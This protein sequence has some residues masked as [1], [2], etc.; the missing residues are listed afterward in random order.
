MTEWS[1][2]FLQYREKAKVELSGPDVILL[3]DTIRPYFLDNDP[4]TSSSVLHFELKTFKARVNETWEK[5]QREL[6]MGLELAEE[7]AESN[8]SGIDQLQGSAKDV[9]LWLAEVS[10]VSNIDD[11]TGELEFSVE[12]VNPELA[13]PDRQVCEPNSE[14]DHSEDKTSAAF[15]DSEVTVDRL[16]HSSVLTP[17]QLSSVLDFRQFVEGF[18]HRHLSAHLNALRMQSGVCTIFHVQSAYIFF[19]TTVGM[20]LM[21]SFPQPKLLKMYDDGMKQSFGAVTCLD[22]VIDTRGDGFLVA[23]HKSGQVCL[24]SIGDRKLMSSFRAHVSSVSSVF[25]LSGKGIISTDISGSIFFSTFR[26]G[27]FSTTVQSDVV[28]EEKN[29]C[30]LQ[31]VSSYVAAADCKVCAV[32]REK[33]LI[34]CTLEPRLWFNS[35]PVRF[36]ESENVSTDLKASL[37]ALRDGDPPLLSVFCSVRGELIVYQLVIE[38]TLKPTQQNAALAPRFSV[39]AVEVTRHQIELSSINVS[40]MFWVSQSL[41]VMYG[42]DSAF[43]VDPFTGDQSCIIH[44][45]PEKSLQFAFSLP[46]F[47]FLLLDLSEIQEYRIRLWNEHLEEL[48]SREEWLRALQLSEN[49][50]LGNIP[51]AVGLPRNVELKRSQCGPVFAQLLQAIA[52]KCFLAF[53]SVKDA[54]LILE[55]CFLFASRTRFSNLLFKDLYGYLYEQQVASPDFADFERV[56]FQLT[57]SFRGSFQEQEVMYPDFCI[58][59]FLDVCEKD[60]GSEDFLEAVLH[61]SST[62]DIVS[63][64]S[65]AFSRYMWKFFYAC[66]RMVGLHPVEGLD[67]VL[68]FVHPF[69]FGAATVSL[70]T[71]RFEELT[72]A[73]YEYVDIAVKDPSTVGFRMDFLLKLLLPCSLGLPVR[74]RLLFELHSEKCI[75]LCTFIIFQVSS[76]ISTR[77]L[78]SLASQAKVTPKEHIT[79]IRQSLLDTLLSSAFDF[80]SDPFFASSI[81]SATKNLVPLYML[82]ASVAASNFAKGIHISQDAFHRCIVGVIHSSV[83]SDMEREQIVIRL[84]ESSAEAQVPLDFDKI[85]KLCDLAGMMLATAVIYGITREFSSAIRTFLVLIKQK[86]QGTPDNGVTSNGQDHVTLQLFEFLR[87]AIALYREDTRLRDAFV[88]HLD[89]LFSISSEDTQ[90]LF[91][92]VF[93]NRPDWV[94]E[95]DGVPLLQFQ[96]LSDWVIV[97]EP[98]GV[99]DSNVPF[100]VQLT[101]TFVRLLCEFERDSAYPFLLRHSS[102]RLEICLDSAAKFRVRDAAA[103][104]LEK[105]GDILSAIKELMTGVLELFDVAY[106]AMMEKRA[107]HLDH[108]RVSRFVRQAIDICARSSQT[109]AEGSLQNCWFFLLDHLIHLRRK[110]FGRLDTL[111]ASLDVIDASVMKNT[112]KNEQLKAKALRTKFELEAKLKE[113]PYNDNYRKSMIQ[114]DDMLA[115]L[116]QRETD[117]ALLPI[118]RETAGIQIPF[119]E[120]CLSQ[121]SDCVE[122]LLTSMVHFVPISLVLG[123]V[124]HEHGRDTVRLFRNTLLFMLDQYQFERSITAAVRRMMADDCIFLFDQEVFSG[125]QSYRPDNVQPSSEIV[126][127]RE[128]AASRIRRVLGGRSIPSKH[129]D[130]VRKE[131]NSSLETFGRPSVRKFALG[132]AMVEVDISSIWN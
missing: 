130:G 98:D 70:S 110:F 26:Q 95:L 67:K 72:C 101:E 25:A 127:K 66:H 4:L 5:T 131:K 33:D 59:R 87:H 85:L 1:H 115:K 50:F 64:A 81:S 28:L 21:Y 108:L 65:K 69:L 68:L 120:E 11:K 7:L 82:V 107:L 47:R 58:L 40:R 113:Q 6:R 93:K 75:S 31:A 83:L 44:A 61:V 35:L 105:T 52:N 45:E 88:E 129:P 123:K 22:V 114:V 23:G 48:V 3:E 62:Q 117:S 89:V 125:N 74:L 49:L 119:C 15:N 102:Y 17:A 42:T 53:S 91:N 86:A 36:D 96:Y 30:I 18:N 29:T 12:R 92:E 9:L 32:I 80:S 71:V 37:A 55:R 39:G 13:A 51:L 126:S 54:K 90:N 56:F 79:G 118:D 112:S 84:L 19:G 10:D 63:F 14:E 111:K 106:S 97:N 43:L 20:V 2:V 41:V 78:E 109:S 76:V 77:E 16:W 46:N 34:L 116:S 103:F 27:V 60:E 104:L 132:S 8:L 124:V 73:T 122:D 57:V 99:F 94:I 128:S 121:I 24:Y 100:L 38:G